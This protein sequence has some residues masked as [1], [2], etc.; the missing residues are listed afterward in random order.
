MG[1]GGWWTRRKNGELYPA[2]VSISAVRNEKG[3]VNKY[4]SVS[5]DITESKQAED[6]IRYL[7]YFDPLTDLPNRTLLRDRTEQLLLTARREQRSAA[8]FY[9]DVDNFQN[10]NDSRRHLTGDQLWQEVARR[11]TH[12]LQAPTA[13]RRARPRPGGGGRSPATCSG[14]ASSRAP[15][16]ARR[17]TP[18]LRAGSTARAGGGR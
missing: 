16:W 13:A 2:W 12:A 9:L 17:P 6:R 8:L 14:G 11:V 10:I 18:T 3:E 7:A 1:G 5:S 15:A 4:I